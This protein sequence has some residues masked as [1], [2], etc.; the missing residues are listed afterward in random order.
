MEF[1]HDKSWEILKSI[2]DLKLTAKEAWNKFIEFHEQTNPKTYW[3]S[4]KNIDIEFEQIEIKEWLEQLIENNPLPKETVALWIGLLK[5]T[6]NEMEVPTI[7]VV[8]TDTYD[9]E[10]IGWACEPTYL[11]ENRYGQPA[12]LKE[13]D[14]M[15]KTDEDNYEFLDWILPLAYSTFTIDEIVRTKLNKTIFLKHH[16]RI[17]FAVGHDSGDYMNLSSIDKN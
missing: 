1:Q 17:N 8:G 11:P 3:T 16:S 4:L 12:L 13:I 2:Y 5:I 9:T 6:D 15:A 7:Y 14:E 10:D